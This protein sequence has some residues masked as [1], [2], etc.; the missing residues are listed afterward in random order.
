MGKDKA[1]R[2][3]TR[4]L[5]QRISSESHSAQAALCSISR[6]QLPRETADKLLELVQNG[7]LIAREGPVIGT[8]ELDESRVRD[9]AG[10][11]P[12]CAYANGAVVVT[13]QHQGRY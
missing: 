13:M 3:I 12:T 6:S 1:Y 2:T 5:M 4:A 8:V 7:L 9:V 10:E 11:M